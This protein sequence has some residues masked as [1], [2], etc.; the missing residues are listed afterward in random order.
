MLMLVVVVVVKMM[1]LKR[2]KSRPDLR[3]ATICSAFAGFFA[4]FSNIATRCISSSA[5]RTVRSK[6]GAMVVWWGIFHVLIVVIICPVVSYRT[7]GKLGLNVDVA[8][9]KK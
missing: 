4:F 5:A 1:M 6:S 3:S 2:E 7:A 9:S 8:A